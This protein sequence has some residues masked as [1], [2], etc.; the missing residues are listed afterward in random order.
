MPVALPLMRKIVLHGGII[1]LLMMMIMADDHL[2]RYK[3][4]TEETVSSFSSRLDHHC[5]SYILV[6]VVINVE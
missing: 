1:A 4:E 6:N 2:S 3:R 5:Y